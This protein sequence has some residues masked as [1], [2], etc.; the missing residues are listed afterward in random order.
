MSAVR[1]TLA[2]HNGRAE[3][4]TMADD[5]TV[6]GPTIEIDGE[7]EGD[8]D[9]VVQGTIR[10]KVV[11]RKDLKVDAGGNVEAVVST[12]NL[13]ITGRVKGN[14]HATGKVELCTEGT[15]IG[16]ITAPRVVLAD[17]SKFKGLI[18]TASEE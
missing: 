9:L 8:E 4:R 13:S 11:S 3:V 10:G 15:M 17:G 6:L 2:G 1:D 7:I 12:R 14:V 18:D 5:R 16:D